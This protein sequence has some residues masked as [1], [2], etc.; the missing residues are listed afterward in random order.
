M[1]ARQ[2]YAIV[3]GSSGNFLCPPGHPNHRWEVRG[4]SSRAKLGTD[5]YF[6]GSV[7]NTAANESMPA[8]IRKDAQ[9]KLDEAQLVCS[10]LWLRYVYGYYA[11][12]YSP[13]GTVRWGQDII[14]KSGPPE[15]HRAHLLVKQYFPDAEPRLDLIADSSGGYGAKTCAKCGT[16]LQY[17]AKVDAFA[18]PITARLHCPSGEQHSTN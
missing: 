1:P 10:E 17:E 7:E 14:E 9:K 11:N 6:I 13:N 16:R 3:P 12:C 2:H 4:A 15:N 5:P 18:E 8:G